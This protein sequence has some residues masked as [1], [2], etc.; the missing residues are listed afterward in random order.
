MDGLSSLLKAIFPCL[1]IGTVEGGI[2]LPTETVKYQ[3]ISEKVSV[4]ASPP[5]G[6]M[7]KSTNDEAAE[8]I[9][10][11]M[12]DADTADSS[13]D[14]T[15][16]SIIREAGWYQ[17]LMEKIL[18][19]LEEVLKAGKPLNA[20]MQKA[21]DEASEALK[22]TEG[23]VIDHPIATEVF[24]TVIALGV[25]VVL[26]PYVVEYLG[27]CAGFGELGPIEGKS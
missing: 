20:A 14:V 11:A 9:V 7:S 17:S 18:A 22:I 1:P 12:F 24:C 21:Y 25:L 13:L 23:F 5:S 26:A 6:K 15:I 16:R 10:S 4:H 2:R 19:K 27:F 8:S 3:L